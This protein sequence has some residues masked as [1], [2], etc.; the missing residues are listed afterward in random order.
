M[1]C[2]CGEPA[3]AS[4]PFDL[5]SSPA[6]A[7]PPRKSAVTAEATLTFIASFMGTRSPHP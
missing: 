3:A 5:L 4:S 2:G 6:A 1:T 7:I